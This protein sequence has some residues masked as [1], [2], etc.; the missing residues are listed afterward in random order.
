MDRKSLITRNLEEVVTEEELDALLDSGKKLVAYAGYEPSGPVHLGHFMSIR[1]LKDLKEAGV[2]VKV[3]MADYHAWLNRKGTLE[4][5]HMWV[6]YWVEVFKALGLE[7][8]FVLGSDYQMDKDY[9]NDLFKF[10]GML[11]INR[12]LRSM[13][14]V[15]RD[16]ENAR[17]SQ[18]IYPLMQALDIKYL[19]LNIAVGGLEQRKIHMIARE[20]LPQ[21]GWVAPVCLHHPLIVSLKGPEIKMSSSVPDSLISVTD[22]PQEIKRKLKNAYCPAKKVEGNPVLQIAK[23]LIFPEQGKLEVHRPAK[24]GGDLEFSSYAD[25]EKEFVNGL[26]PL[27]L[28][29]AVSDALSQILEPAR[30]IPLPEIK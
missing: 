4:Q 1:K 11:T 20:Y 27:D 10:A 14:Q 2:H 18:I 21:L 30:E 8:E 13:Q 29:N 26:H 19:G 6:D 15:A 25:L 5:L 7:A 17:V 3:L 22:S 16:I 28:K 9:V 24:F 12:A 23:Y